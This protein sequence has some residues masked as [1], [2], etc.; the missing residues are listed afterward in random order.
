MYTLATLWKKLTTTSHFF[1]KYELFE[2]RHLEDRS[3][4]PTCHLT[5][6]FDQNC[7]ENVC[8]TLL[9]I[10]LYSENIR[11]WYLYESLQ[12]ADLLHPIVYTIFFEA[13]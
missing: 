12:K 7:H 6:T 5:E 8:H 2:V 11:Y 4:S 10:A 1:G 13:K 3:K 9:R